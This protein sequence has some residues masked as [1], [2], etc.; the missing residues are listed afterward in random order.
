MNRPTQVPDP[1]AEDQAS[2]W[3]A[4]LEGSMLTPADRAELDA[5]LAGDPGRRELL[6]RYCQFSAKLDRLVPELVGAGLVQMPPER[7]RSLWNPWKVAAAGLLAASLVAA[8]VWTGRPD[9][10]AREHLHAGRQ[11][12]IVHAGGRNPRR[13]ERQHQHLR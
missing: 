3:A 1:S 11:E 7:T 9:L 12:G 4:R 6:S 5:W 2:L 8:A 10:Q 13:A